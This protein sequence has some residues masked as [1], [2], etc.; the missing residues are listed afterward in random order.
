MI[1]PQ[2]WKYW[3]MMTIIPFI[4][5]NSF[6]FSFTNYITFCLHVLTVLMTYSINLMGVVLSNNYFICTCYTLNEL[7]LNSF[8]GEAKAL[9]GLGVYWTG[10]DADCHEGAL[11]ALARPGHQDN[12][13]GGKPLPPTVP[14]V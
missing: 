5:V 6:S 4:L 9:L 1:N 8:V 3:K 11:L 7:I 13:I 14:P 12:T 10:G 2:Q